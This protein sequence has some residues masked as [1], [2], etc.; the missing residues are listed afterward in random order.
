M[1]KHTL[2]WLLV[3][4]FAAA[5]LASARQARAEGS[6]IEVLMQVKP[7]DKNNP[8]TKDDAPQVEVTVIGAPNLPSEK[9]TLREEGAKQPI[10]LKPSSRR[11]YNQGTEKLAIAIVM[12]GWE[13]WIGNDHVLPDD[14]PSRYPGVLEAFEQALD[15]VNFKDA[16][17]A[18]SLG[19]VI[20]YADKAVVRIP[21]GPLEKITGSQLGTQR[22]Y[23]GT[24]GVELVKGV[25][26][27]LTELHKVQVSRKVLIVV[28]DGMDTN[29][30]AAKGQLTALKAQAKADQVQTFAII[31]KAPLSGDGNVISTM[32]PQ[33][34][35]VTSAD[36]IATAIA[37]ILTRM[38][39]RQYLTFPGFDPKSGLGLTWDGKPHNLIL[40]VDKD[41]TD[42]VQLTMAPPWNV[43]KPGFPWLI[44]IIVVVGALVLLIIGIKIFSSKPAPLPVPIA[45]PV[46][47]EAPK[48]MGPAKTVMIGAGGDEGGFPI[49]G[50]LV[51]LNGTQAY[52]TFR[53]RSGGTK[54]GTAPP[55]DIVINDGFMS[56]E[57]CQINCSPQGFML[58]DGGST[59]GCYVNDRKISG[60]QDLV[61]NDMVTLGKTNFKFKSIN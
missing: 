26:L 35:T 17:P 14:D 42:P 61:D 2:R 54:I 36:N 7:P 20:T 16:G 18:G 30:E 6:N 38:A 28:C 22:D 29:M 13:I 53:L 11:D 60:K 15:K 4:M 24:K 37:G 57:H 23:L 27:A 39:D 3:P 33:T 9:F 45:A 41:D 12:N 58:V 1:M 34:Q 56:T 59:N 5:W 51:P 52:Q 55:C 43:A 48:P 47:V 21:M 31:Y 8:K 10:E 49:V 32:I 46:V 44:L 40:K 19:T 50:W 25:D